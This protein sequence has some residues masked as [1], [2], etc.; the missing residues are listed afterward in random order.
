MF[1]SIFALAQR[2]SSDNACAFGSGGF[3]TVI[4][5][6]WKK[7]TDR[8]MKIQAIR[9]MKDVLP[10]EV[11]TWQKVEATARRIFEIYGF[12]EFRTP[13]LEKTELFARSIGETTDIVEK[14]MY[15]FP[16]RNQ[17]S[18]T[19]RP[20]AT[21]GILR[22]YIEHN[23]FR[24]DPLQK[25]YCIGPMFRHERPQKGRYRQFHQIDA[26]TLGTLDP[27]SDAELLAMLRALFG[28]LGLH[29]LDFQINSLGCPVCRPGFK[30]AVL[31]FL[32]GKTETLC[33]DCQRRMKLNPLRIYDCKAEGCRQVVRNAPKILDSLC[34]ACREHL[35]T[36]ESHLVSLGIPYSL[37]PYIVRGLDYYIR[38]TFEVISQD[39]GAQNAVCGGGRYDQLIEALGG[40]DLPAIG[41][42]IGEE[43]LVAILME[44]AP[45]EDRALELFVAAIGADAERE[46]FLWVERARS[47][48][49]QAE[50]DWRS[51]S[52]KAQL[53][54]ADK[55]RAQQVLI[56]GEEEL[57]SGRATV[58][59]MR[60]GAQ[61]EVPLHDLLSDLVSRRSGV[62]R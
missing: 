1:I 52:L 18:L 54:R 34:T 43:R 11:E 61:R 8:P 35:Q 4:S 36:L 62:A 42:A 9:G 40:P 44:K 46:A 19:L 45:A 3:R 20:E 37:N 25:V 41:F 50:M 48:G 58:R 59:D 51:G 57:R 31:A 6:R 21:A 22:A 10:G 49:M 47:L 30:D 13:L 28:E 15:T 38:T 27:R 17:V 29:S 23:I 7:R 60:Q 55:R 5:F 2:L 12:A 26:E 56:L 33:A 39:L 53:R 32:D 14:E 16:D 24:T